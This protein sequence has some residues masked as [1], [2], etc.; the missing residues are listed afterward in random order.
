M[1]SSFLFGDYVLAC[2]DEHSFFTSDLICKHIILNHETG[3]SS[4]LVSLFKEGCDNICMDD[5]EEEPMEDTKEK[6][7]MDTGED[8]VMI[9]DDDELDQYILP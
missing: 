7:Y 9:E 4:E 3:F 5:E 2:N 8:A 6:K 1:S